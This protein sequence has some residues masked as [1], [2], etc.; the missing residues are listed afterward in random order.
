M[1][2]QM[3]TLVA[4]VEGGDRVLLRAMG[5][6]LFLGA[7]M[8][9]G[10]SSYNNPGAGNMLGQH[11]LIGKHIFMIVVGLLMMF[12]LANTNYHHLRRRWLNWPAVAIAMVLMV[13]TLVQGEGREINRWVTIFGFSF[14]PVELAKMAVIL[15][16]AER[17]H[18][19]S[20]VGNLDWRKIGLA[21]V[22]GPLPLF[23]L[24]YKQ[25]NYGN[26]L[27]MGT[28]ILAL[29]LVAG[30]DRRRMAVAVGVP[31]VGAVL[32]F[33]FSS[34]L[35]RR[36][37]EWWGGVQGGSFGYQ[38]D[39]ALMGIG[40]GGPLGL[41]P[42][43]GH[44]KFNF[45]PEAHTDFIYSVMGE[46]LGSWGTLLVMAAFLTFIWR[47]YSI[48]SRAADPF[49]RMVATGLTTALAVY[50]L[51]NIGM[52]M[53]VFPVVGIPLPF[54]SFGGT[55][56]VAALASVGILLNIDRRSAIIHVKNQRARDR[57]RIV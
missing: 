34:K 19:A 12:V 53:G 18:H 13:M 54:V 32:A 42:G 39:Q 50:G 9:Y 25:P 28:V 40:A 49:G 29:L 8:V 26:L 3:R 57:S 31:A 4:A 51:V 22:L 6:M 14:Q 20:H 2:R 17:W 7:I 1:N 41:G 11:F 56:M 23:L 21:L 48:A 35:A 46:E 52:V 38:V 55:A 45:L 47:G 43:K 24:L 33:T 27:T 16:L 36:L 15:F 44:N 37:G 5:I 10:A 30:L